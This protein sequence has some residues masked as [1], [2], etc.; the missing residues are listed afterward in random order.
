M[1]EWKEVK[2][3]DI[4]KYANTGADAIKK[5]PIVN[6]DTG[7]RCIRIGDLSH[8]RDYKEWGFTNVN[9]DIFEK[10]KLQQGDI[11][12]A[13]TGNTIGVV[14]YINK[15]LIAVY[16]NGL[17]RLQVNNRI[18]SKYLFYIMLSKNFQNFIQ[19][20]A[21]GT[22][23]QPNMKIRD[24]LN[25]RFFIP[26]LPI[27]KKIADI[28]SVID[29]KIETLQNINETLEEMAK[30]IFKSWFVDFEIVK[31][32]ASGKNDSE[33][34]EEFGINEEIVKL[35]PSEFIDSE[36]G[37]IPKGWEVKKLKELIFKANTGADAIRKA[38]IVDY[39]TGIRCV[40]VGDFSNKRNFLEWGFADVNEKVYEAYKLEK[41]DIL[42]TRTSFI[43][44]SKIIRQNLSAVY[45]NGLIRIKPKNNAEYLYFNF[46]STRFKNYINR[47]S[48]ETSTRQ[49]MK[50]NYL[51]DYKIIIPNKNILEI[52]NNFF[53][54]I[55]DNIENNIHQIQTLQE[56]RDT[57]LPKLINRE[58]EVD[59]LDIKG[60]DEFN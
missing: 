59:K 1:S 35:F 19:S 22:S 40:R 52:I 27:Q 45:N 50:I 47:I 7:I 9:N 34:A 30:A 24:M 46:Q 17:I 31:A 25:Y 21:Y 54:M 53:N 56:L 39:D 38:P 13:R 12:I 60:L 2:L 18:L 37:K 14:T 55:L 57:L 15:K 4:I 41:N 43:G 51:L 26:P 44:L 29:E 6:Y 48:G 49:N 42:I 3:G 28:L 20:I 32:K 10:Y 11:L 5:A 23:T 8:K 58:I 16:N 36:I 33:I